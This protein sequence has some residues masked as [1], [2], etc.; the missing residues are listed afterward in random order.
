MW[1]QFCDRCGKKTTNK[2]AF[3]LPIENQATSNYSYLC[4]STKFG[5]DT[6]TL[7]NDCLEDFKKFRYEH[8]RYN[9]DLE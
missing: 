1:V 3:L 7:C 6:V 2:A 4:N 8:S 9:R 5:G